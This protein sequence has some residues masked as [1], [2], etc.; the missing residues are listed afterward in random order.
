[1]EE[2]YFFNTFGYL[3]LPIL[4]K[5]NI[6]LKFEEDISRALSIEYIGDEKAYNGLNQRTSNLRNSN[7]I[8]DEIYS[9]FYNNEVLDT[10]K[11]ITN[12]F[13]VLSPIESFYL[14]KTDIHRDFCG[15]IKTIKILYY[16]DD[17]SDVNKG[18]L[19]VI[20]GTQF[21][22]DKYSS[23]IG[24]NV[25]WPPGVRNNTGAGFNLY[26]DYLKENIP[27]KYL[28]S[29]KDKIIF[30]NNT[31]LHGSDGNS[32]ENSLLRRALGMTLV[33]V[34]R[35]NKKMMDSVDK[36]FSFFDINNKKS[37]AYLYCEKNKHTLGGWLEHFY[38]YK[39]D[40]LHNNLDGISDP[41]GSKRSNQ[42][43]RFKHYTDHLE[44]ISD[45][46][47]NDTIHNCYLNQVTTYDF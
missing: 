18:P 41:D 30:F 47:S 22:Y 43:N 45:E 8:N 20:P 46:I 1:M 27:K 13:I 42:I 6:I 17:V 7:F 33:V 36:L 40:N 31:L 38:E 34:D 37:L 21:I 19:Y 14:Y 2:R 28:F 11:K 12:D 10:L 26:S 35:N 29:N 25:C 44:N 3:Q 4:K 16:L 15:E 39:C 24:D 9:V 5:D 32:I 23:S